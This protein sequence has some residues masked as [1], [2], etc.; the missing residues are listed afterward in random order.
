M[1]SRGPDPA[2]SCF[3]STCTRWT[4]SRIQRLEQAIT[5]AVATSYAPVIQALQALR[6]VTRV[7]VVTVVSEG[8]SFARFRQAGQVM[9]DAGLVPREYLSGASRWCGGITKTGNAHLLRRVVVEAAWAYRHSA[10]LKATL[11]RRQVGQSPVVQDIAWRAQVR[12]HQK[13][14]R[15]IHR[16]KGGGVATA[17][18]AR[19]LL[20]FMWAVACAVEAGSAG[21]PAA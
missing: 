7:T 12:L 10:A 9:G 8:G 20:G 1:R 19:E 13:W 21:T 16:G 6:G 4:R 17:A 11:R 14:E 18:V 5:D 15:L 2:A 3:G